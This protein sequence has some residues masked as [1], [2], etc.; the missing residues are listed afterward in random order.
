MSIGAYPGETA[1]QSGRR[2]IVVGYIILGIPPRLNFGIGAISEGFAAT[3]MVTIAAAIVPAIALVT[4]RVRPKWF[5]VVVNVLLGTVILETVIPTVM[6]GGLLEADLLMGFTVIVVVGALIALSARA[7]FWWFIAYLVSLVLAV[8]LPESISSIYDVE[9]GTP[10]TIVSVLVS[11]AIFVYAG[12]AYFVRQRDR[13]QKES[14]DL[15]HNILPN[16]IATRLKTDTSMIA[17]DFPNASVLFADVVGFTPM[18]ANMTPPQLVG[19]LN[20]VFSKFDEFVEELSLEKI[21]TVGDEYMVAAGVPTPRLD[22]AVPIAD[23]ALRIRDH[24]AENE[25]DG[26]RLTM[27][28]GIHSGP[29]VAGIIGTHKFSYDLWGDTVNTASRME[30]EGIPGQIQVSPATYEVL[31]GNGYLFEPRGVI[32]VKGKGDMETWLLTGRN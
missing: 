23:L 19:L 7:A 5:I 4:L 31:A 17:D 15:L 18:S 24:M 16:E 27:R 14:D 20:S 2:R 3:G 6:L 28:I 29:V 26:H 25:F 11:A 32:S 30:S 22:H 8:V 9:P 13:F 1:A 21:K 10:A 12:M